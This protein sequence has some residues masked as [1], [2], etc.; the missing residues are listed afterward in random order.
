MSEFDEQWGPNP[1]YATGQLAR[2]LTTRQEHDDPATR[3]RA[4]KRVAK[5]RRV[6]EGMLTGALSVGSRAPVKDAPV[7]A[8]LEVV[9]G[10]F[11]TGRLLAGGALQP[12]EE[13]WL[14][15]IANRPEVSGRA[16]LNGYFVSDA[17]IRDLGE[18]LESGCYRVRMPEEGAL[19][20]VAWLLRHGDVRHARAV[21]DEIVPLFAKLRF[22]PVPDPRPLTLTST[23]YVQTTEETIEQLKGLRTRD[24]ILTMREALQVWTPLYDRAA[25][26][27]AET[28]EG[29]VPALRTGADGKPWRGESGEF[30]IVGGWPCQHYPDDWPGR[31][32][33][34]LAD[35]RELRRRHRRCRKPERPCENFARLRGYLEIAAKD[36][37]RLTGADVGMVRLILASIETRRGLP[38]SPRC[39]ALRQAQ[40]ADARRPSTAELAKVLAA[41]LAKLPGDDGLDSLGDVTAPVTPEEARRFQLPAQSPFP[42]DLLGK[43]ERCRKAPVTDLVERRVISSGEVLGRVVPQLTSHVAGSTIKDPDLG[44]LFSAIYLAFRKRRSLLLMN[45]E[46]Q[47]KLRELPWVAAIEPYRGETAGAGQT[48]RRTLDQVVTL[49]VKAFPHMILP[50][51][52]LQEIRALCAEANLEVPIVDEIAADIFMGAFSEKFLTAAKIAAEKLSGT[53]YETYYG[54]SYDYV[55]LIEDSKPSRYGAATSHE[56][57]TTCCELADEPASGGS[58]SVARSGKILEQAQILTT[59]NLAPLFSALD[60]DETLRPE[61]GELARRCFAWTCHA[62]Q[63]RIEDWR[64]RLKTL[65]NTAYAW[66]QMIFFLS[67]CPRDEALEFLGWADEHLRQQRE[68]FRARF[69]PALAGLERALRGEAPGMD[70]EARRFLGWTTGK[71]WLRGG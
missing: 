39:A 48:A 11:T 7:W 34:L 52:L 71:H 6:L 65:K 69:S 17:G 59:H 46:S 9:T 13:R 44:R 70:G 36:P 62:L 41:R 19:L 55:R 24:E 43:L 30:D 14:D 50:N 63:L 38:G 33:K 64:R 1:G 8:T 66:R 28:V 3:N 12:H 25:A 27:F 35:Y 31:A 51:K 32:R 21:L 23:V 2:A 60:L 15:R 37:S 42:Q 29:E 57:Y 20:A 49:A 47:V 54:I 68:T 53:L 16:A 61:L 10:G 4:E 18:I 5:W 56:F 40:V 22:Y 26:L 58:W 67:L 45:L